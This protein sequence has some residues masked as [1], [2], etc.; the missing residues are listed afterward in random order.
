[1]ESN[2]HNYVYVYSLTSYT[3]MVPLIKKSSDI[4]VEK[5][6]EFAES[7]KTVELF[8]YIMTMGKI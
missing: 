7:G 2:R 3:Q 4:L 8:R 6:G 5:M 1:M